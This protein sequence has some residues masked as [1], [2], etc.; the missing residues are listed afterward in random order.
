MI[1]LFF[2]GKT[3]HVPVCV[4]VCCRAVIK[5][6]VASSPNL[7]LIGI[8][9]NLRTVRRYLSV[10]GPTTLWVRKKAAFENP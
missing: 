9:I 5:N 2:K 8:N 10:S 4:N 1:A 6:I 3:I 7:I